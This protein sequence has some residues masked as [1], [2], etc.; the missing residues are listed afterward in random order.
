MHIFQ[1]HAAAHVLVAMLHAVAAGAPLSEG[2]QL[3][4]AVLHHE[5][6][7]SEVQHRASKCA[8]MKM[9]DDDFAAAPSSCRLSNVLRSHMVLQRNKP[10]NLWGFGSPGATV[11]I[12]GTSRALA[13]QPPIHATVAP[14]GTWAVAL[15]PQP[16]S[17]GGAAVNFSFACSTG[18]KFAM[19]DVLFGDVYI[20]EQI[21]FCVCGVCEC[22]R[23][24]LSDLPNS[25][26]GSR[27]IMLPVYHGTGQVGV[28]RTCSTPS[29]S[30]ASR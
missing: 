20:C 21:P 30:S 9:D 17:S 27:P 29:S 7:T 11:S 5:A 1:L 16:A 2:T 25:P 28:N 18:E 8:A 22:S 13:N 19:D 4:F 23:R 6:Q 3:V 14:N 24:A 26:A 15:A 12:T 10:A